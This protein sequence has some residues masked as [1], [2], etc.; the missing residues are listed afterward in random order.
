ML[1]YSTSSEFCQGDDFIRDGVRRLL[2]PAPADSEIWINRFGVRLAGTES[3]V[4]KVLRN[5][6]PVAEY[7]PMA[8]AFVCA[9]TPAWLNNTRDW[10]ELC[11]EHNVPIWLIGVGSRQNNADMLPLGKHL[12]EVA[13]TRDHG[14][15]KMLTAAG[16]PHERFLDPGF[17]APYFHPRPKIFPV[18]LTYR[19]RRAHHECDQEGR[20]AAYVALWRKFRD[21]IAAVVV[22]EP[23][24]IAHARRLFGVEP[25]FSHDWRRYA[26]VYCATEHYIGGRLHGAI[27]VLAG[28][29]TAHLLYCNAKT[30]GVTAHDWLPVTCHKHEAWDDIAL[31]RG[32]DPAEVRAR[33]Q[34][35]FTA[36]RGYIQEAVG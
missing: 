6:P 27:P 18:V 14:A 23:D 3:N 32:H 20:E 34:A 10:W 19:H 31:G 30:E 33:I 7:L 21:A 5:M 8:R 9:G 29:G 11:I 28:G 24:E 15:G 13:T 25:F 36:H 2:D 17:H 16:V 12:I 22:H 35:D 1:I 26:E 4:W